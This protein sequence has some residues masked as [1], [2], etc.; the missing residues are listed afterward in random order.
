LTA[1]S[2]NFERTGPR[3][4]AGEGVVLKG[5]KNEIA[6]VNESQVSLSLSEFWEF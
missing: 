2:K 4:P 6:S 3:F 1:Q 5:K